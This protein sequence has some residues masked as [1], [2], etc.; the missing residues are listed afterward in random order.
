MLLR[1]IAGEVALAV[2]AVLTVRTAALL[3]LLAVA[4]ADAIGLALEN[5]PWGALLR[6]ATQFAAVVVWAALMRAYAPF[7]GRTVAEPRRSWAYLLYAAVVAC[8]P[9]LVYLV[10]F[11]VVIR[12]FIP[13]T[14]SVAVWALFGP[15]ALLMVLAGWAFSDVAIRGAGAGEA[16]RHVLSAARRPGVLARA[17]VVC[18]LWLASV[19]LWRWAGQSTAHLP[20]GTLLRAAADI[21]I[22]VVLDA[23]TSALI[24][25]TAPPHAEPVPEPVM[26]EVAIDPAEA[27]P[28]QIRRTVR[29]R[30]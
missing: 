27:P 4:I 17:L 8:W 25:A 28:S 10:A 2:R 14:S 7:L 18:A 3:A 24:V 22:Y 1:T 15:M 9:V 30:R 21:A 5:G 16:I 6:N 12:A 19:P 11:T 20:N 26:A 29:R 13:V 23:V